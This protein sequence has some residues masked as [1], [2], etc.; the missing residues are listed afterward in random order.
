MEKNGERADGVGIYIKKAAN[1]VLSQVVGE[2]VFGSGGQN[3]WEERY[4]QKQVM[5]RQQ[6]GKGAVSHESPTI[7]LQPPD[8]SHRTSITNSRP[9]TVH[10]AFRYSNGDGGSHAHSNHSNNNNHGHGQGRQSLGGSKGKT[11][12]TKPTATSTPVVLEQT[13][14]VVELPVASISCSLQ[15]VTEGL[16]ELELPVVVAAASPIKIVSMVLTTPAENKSA[17][18]KVLPKLSPRSAVLKNVHSARPLTAQPLSKAVVVHAAANRPP[19]GGKLQPPSVVTSPTS[20]SKQSLSVG[21]ATHA[22]RLL[23]TMRQDK[24][25]KDKE[26]DKPKGATTSA[27]SPLLSKSLNGPINSLPQR[28]TSSN[29]S[30][31]PGRMSLPSTKPIPITEKAVETSLPKQSP[32]QEAVASDLFIPEQQGVL[33]GQVDRLD[34]IAIYY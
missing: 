10:A 26:K 29:G 28:A 12:P 34:S 31:K 15:T 13:E 25:V 14:P 4:R 20:T 2:K 32:V 1:L 21:G 22:V 24:D 3:S 30:K 6:K 16:A 23:K 19:V 18:T 17:L 11:T 27:P 7:S 33:V 8:S 9:Q 5:K